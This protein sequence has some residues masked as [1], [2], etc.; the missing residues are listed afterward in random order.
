[1]SLRTRWC[2]A[3]LVC[4]AL[5]VRVGVAVSLGLDTPP[6][7]GSDQ[8]EYDAYAWNVAQGRG[9]RGLSPDVEDQDHLTAFRP[10]LP[11][12]VWAGVYR[13]WG[14]RYDLIR[15][16]HCAMG[17]AAV[18]LVFFIGRRCF[19]E[20]VGLAAAA[21]YAV[22]P[23]AV[24]FT[25]DLMSE[26]LANLLVL[27]YLLVSLQFAE[28]PSAGRAGLAGL[29]LGLCLLTRSNL[30]L[31]VP[32][33]GVWALWQFR[34]RWR[35]LA[36][37]LA[38]PVVAGLVLVPWTVRNYLVFDAFVPLSTM[39]GSA[40]LQGNNRIVVT[41]PR[42][43]GYCFWDSNIPEYRN[44]LKAPNDEVERDRVAK[45]LAIE[46]LKENPDKWGF[47]VQAKFRRA[48]SPFLYS[49]TPRAFRIGMLAS[50]G[51]V[52]TLFALAF[53][54]TLW[55]FLKAGHAGWLL[56]LQPVQFTL[57]SVVFFGYSRYRSPIEPV[58]IILALGLVAAAARWLQNGTVSQSRPEGSEA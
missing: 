19:D 11:S 17:A 46:W 2:L 5:A 33:A 22:F 31:M 32:M 10:P 50:W 26:A 42:Y 8:H 13:V 52:V 57:L 34:H 48:W 49:E 12:L 47:L 40:L 37:G 21:V 54:P 15:L 16:M 45:R 14:Q 38:I 36:L 55:W 30:A 27:G 51:P 23:T 25:I 58:C 56:H 20:R 9:Y 44:L 28:R 1:M 3:V 41:E 53:I 18:A 4:L 6:E 39:G 7:P 29:L 35:D 24:Y 43:F